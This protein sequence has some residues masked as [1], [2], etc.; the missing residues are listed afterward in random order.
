[1]KML[2]PLLLAAPL[3]TGCVATYSKTV[4]VTKDANGKTSRTVTVTK[5]WN[6][7]LTTN[8]TVSVTQPRQ[9]A[10]L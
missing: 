1:M 6:G 5:D 10:G 8:T 4:D 7:K 2:L 3:F 9:R